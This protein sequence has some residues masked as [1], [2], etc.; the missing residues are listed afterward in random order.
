MGVDLAD[1]SACQGKKTE[2]KSS[3]QVLTVNIEVRQPVA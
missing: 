2:G 1:G 3:L